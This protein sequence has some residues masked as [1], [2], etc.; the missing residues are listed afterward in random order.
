MKYFSTI[1]LVFFFLEN[2][3]ASFKNKEI[4]EL[5]KKGFELINQDMVKA[6][7]LI[8]LAWQESRKSGNSKGV[9]DGYFY[10]GCLY[11]R[12]MK[13]DSAIQYLNKANTLYHLINE[14]ENVPDSY[15]RLGML[16][17]KKNQ[18]QEGLKHL[19]EALKLAQELKNPQA[20]IR[21]TIVFAMHMNDFTGQYDVAI[22]YLREAESSAKKL[23][24]KALLGHIYLQLSISYTKKGD[25]DQAIDFS[26]KSLQEF[27]KVKST[28]NQ[29]RALFTLADVYEQKKESTKVLEVLT[30]VRPLLKENPDDLMKANYYKLLAE[31]YY[32][33]NEF[34]KALSYAEYASSLLKGGGQTQSVNH[35]NEILFRIH[36]ILGNRVIAD[37][38]YREYTSSRDSVF[39]LNS[40]TV[41]AELREKYEAQKRTQQIDVQMLELKNAKFLRQSLLGV[42]IFAVVLCIVIYG[43]LREKARNEHL[44]GLKNEKIERQYVSL[45]QMNE[46]NET[47][48]REIHHRVKNNIQIISSLFSIQARNIDHPAV[49]N[50]IEKSKSRLKTISIIHN[51]LYTQKSLSKIKMSDFVK[52]IG[53]SLFEIYN[54]ENAFDA[55]L[56]LDIKGDNI[57]LNAD[58]SLPL[59]LIINELI[60]N[61]LKYAFQ[62]N[63]L[64]TQ[65]DKIYDTNYSHVLEPDY[66]SHRIEISIN[67]ISPNEFALR[68][69][70][71]GPGLDQSVDIHTTSTT[72]LRL[73][74]G[75]LQQLNGSIDYEGGKDDHQFIVL[76]KEID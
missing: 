15:G 47:L 48:L 21:N 28:Y 56:K 59:G 65:A 57:Y 33:Q 54:V 36:Y 29:M 18:P 70:D 23:N 53:E 72:G 64:V 9:A 12:Q 41:D 37:S 16:L 74:R 35:L 45:R 22:N 38:L 32:E 42:I 4:Q 7:S 5:Y 17:I 14:W 75:L 61:S 2:A 27:I 31:A 60:T 43:R 73:I 44:L 11:D 6:D 1:F 26:N 52:E 76:F 20:L 25:Y 49:V 10:K 39:S 58:T 69:S 13:I 3:F 46:Y 67:K 63:N 24:E 8:S 34:K 30:Q 66:L 71:S 40:V 62:E 50:L 68:Y 55:S 19:L 51:T